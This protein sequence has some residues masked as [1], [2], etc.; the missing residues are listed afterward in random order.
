[1]SLTRKLLAA[2]LAAALSLPGAAS[3]QADPDH[4]VAGGGTL[5]AGWRARTERNAPLA[6]VKFAAM[7][8]GYHV[9]LGPA[10]IFWRDADTISGNYHLVATFAQTKAPQHP[11][12]YGLILGGRSLADS[13]QSYTYF[14]IR[15]MPDKAEF[16]IRRRA[17]Y[18][19]RPTAVVDWTANA[20]VKGADAE[21]KAT[22]ELSILV[23][24]GTV[25]FLVNG[26]AVHTAKATDVDVSG[27]VGYR[28]N[29]NLDLHLGP[30]GIHKQ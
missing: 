2:A 6:N 19:T 20:A 18:A 1:M 30:L 22:N 9:T 3:A 7:G 4:A 8:T 10:T 16:S 26:T 5:P 17:G 13:T 14:I 21:G 12:A 28:V 15:T 29:H 11:E 24:G 27:I 23:S 25:T